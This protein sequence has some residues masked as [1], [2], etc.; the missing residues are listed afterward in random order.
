MD[1]SI[2]IRGFK[3]NIVQIEMDEDSALQIGTINYSDAGSTK[4]KKQKLIKT[5]TAQHHESMG[6]SRGFFLGEGNEGGKKEFLNSSSLRVNMDSGRRRRGGYES[7]R[8]HADRSNKSGKS[9]MNQSIED[10]IVVRM[11]AEGEH[12]F[13]LPLF[14]TDSV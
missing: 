10:I 3:P 1:K 4:K 6:D 5:K 7:P 13:S 14:A 8:S 9:S 12:I 11:Y 2:E